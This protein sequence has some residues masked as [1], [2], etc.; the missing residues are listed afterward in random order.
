MRCSAISLVLAAFIGVAQAIPQSQ[1]ESSKPPPPPPP[2]PVQVI[3]LPLPPV[4]DST[5]GACTLKINAKGTGCINRPLGTFHAG[6]FTP[7]DKHVVVNVQYVGAPPAPDPASIYNGEH[8]IL[9]KTDGTKFGN[10]DPWKCL[11]CGVPAENARSVQQDKSYP[12]VFRNGRKAIW[13]LNILECGGANLESESCKPENTYIYPLYWPN[14]VD[15]AGPGGVPR[16][17]RVHPDDNHLGFSSFTNFNGQLGQIAYL[18]LLKFNPIPVSGDTRDPRYDIVDV[19]VLF[20]PKGK[21]IISADGTKLII[22]NEAINVGELRGFSGTG[23][24]VTCIGGSVEANNMDV[25]A[26]HL[27]TGAVRRLTSHPEY[28]DPVAFSADNKWI[29]V[30]DTRGSN[31]LMWAAA[32]RGIPPLA[33]MVTAAATAA[34]RNNLQRRFFQPILLDGFGDRDPYYGQRL[35]PHDDK[36]ESI[37]D[38]NWNGRADPAFSYDGTKIVYWQALV[39]SPSCG[40]GNP[41]PCP[42][43]TAQGGRE[44]RLM[45]ATLS[46]RKAQKV[47][48]VFDIGKG[49]P[50]AVRY[51]PGDALPR[52][53]GLKTGEY[54]LKGQVSGSA[55]VSITA[56]PTGAILH[57]AATYVNFNSDGKHTIN[58]YENITNIPDPQNRYKTELIWFS[59]LVGTGASTSTKK[60]TEGG[61]KLNIEL[62]VNNFQATGKL[63]STVDGV[64]YEPPAN[65]T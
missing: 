50:W 56:A 1:G 24:E 36:P 40:G 55:E 18:G 47:P 38:P 37:G 54:T 39:V 9:V 45:L 16:E 21:G 63:I 28:V 29:V 44:Y 35:N 7:D 22:N 34:S 57:V 6:G 26:V 25:F 13:G 59:D 41:L 51:R 46:S 53:E 19:D 27:K 58:G 4:S 30:M 52:R 31:R 65:G 32:M 17:L 8:L 43:S 49:V 20:D 62:M 3:E 61:F 14:T 11:S 60:S 48:K 23:D 64:S 10:G 42:A 12:H 2:E 33:D 15:G 5:T